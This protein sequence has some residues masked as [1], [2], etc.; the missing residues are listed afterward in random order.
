MALARVLLVH[1]DNVPVPGYRLQT[2]RYLRSF[3]RRRGYEL[4]VHVDDRFLGGSHAVPR[5]T[6]CGLARLVAIVR[7]FRP[8]VC[9]LVVNHSHPYFFPFVFFLGLQGVLRITWTH[10]ANLQRPSRRSALV[11]H[12]EHEL[13]DGIVLYSEQLRGHLLRRHRHK[14]FVANNTL[15][16]SSYAMPA[17]D[18]RA[19]LARHGI[20][21]RLNIIFVGR[22]QP[23]KRLED[24]VSAFVM[25]N[26][27]ECGL[28]VVGPDDE[29]ILESVA[30]GIPRVYALGSLYGNDV[31][32]L[33]RSADVYC[34][35]GAIGLSIV[36]AM[37]CGLPVV[38]EDVLHGP[39]I[40]YLRDGE[41]GF[42]VP[43]GDIRALASR[44]SLLLADDGLRVRMSARARHE[45]A[46]R[47]HIDELCKGVLDCVQFVMHRTGHVRTG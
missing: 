44:L 27:A 5:R 29:G 21:T 45:I 19:T 9:I 40:M 1:H 4:C 2:Y 20:T 37:Y 38:T 23:R 39:E 13:C 26:E 22:I 14:A 17:L 36:D 24:L 8:C 34:I 46:T 28:I 33:L 42:M 11:H 16:L 30:Q 35:P 15:N 41:N 32:D 43:R 10:G 31:L 12:A 47:G 25:L 18:R 6:G 7:R 3:L